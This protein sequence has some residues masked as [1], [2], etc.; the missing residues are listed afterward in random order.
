MIA[1]DIPRCKGVN[2]TQKI[3]RA[4]QMIN[5]WQNCDYLLQME[6]K[7]MGANVMLKVEQLFPYPSLPIPSVLCGLCC[8]W[9]YLMSYVAVS[10]RWILCCNWPSVFAVGPI[11]LSSS[12]SHTSYFFP[13]LRILIASKYPKSQIIGRKILD[14][15]RTYIRVLKERQI[16]GQN[17]LMSVSNRS[18]TSPTQ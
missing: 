12:H 4:G 11:C 9:I 16:M 8:S 7:S 18:F 6:D 5:W 17:S 2:R 3:L 13:I 1:S 14:K 15:P 10:E